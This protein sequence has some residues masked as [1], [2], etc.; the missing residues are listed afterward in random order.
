MG[1]AQDDSVLVIDYRS[2]RELS[3]LI[4]GA[5]ERQDR[6]GGIGRLR[7]IVIDQRDLDRDSCRRLAIAPPDQDA[8]Y[9]TR[10]QYEIGATRYSNIGFWFDFT[11]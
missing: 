1:S 4:G 5:L 11:T 10:F 9:N 6:R 2:D 3:L 7:S 8:P